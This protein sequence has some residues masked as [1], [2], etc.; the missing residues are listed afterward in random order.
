NISLMWHSPSG[1]Y[2]ARANPPLSASSIPDFALSSPPY[3]LRSRFVYPYPLL[4]VAPIAAV[5]GAFRF[6]IS[7]L[8]LR[9]CVGRRHASQLFW[10]HVQ[11]VSA[12]RVSVTNT[13]PP[14]ADNA[15]GV[16]LADT[17]F[18]PVAIPEQRRASPSALVPVLLR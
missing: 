4:R 9:R 16:R 6:R 18:L 1:V 14:L 12:V 11:P 5:A 8:L 3:R 2:I 17:G 13:R 10:R 7:P 15:A